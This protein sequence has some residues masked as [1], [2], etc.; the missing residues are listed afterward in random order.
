MRFS[1]KG[2]YALR[3]MLDLAAQPSQNYIPL[4]DI[5]QRQQ[6]S[7]KYLEQI[8][9]LLGK[10]HMVESIRGAAGGYR[11][12]RPASQY[13]CGDILRTTEGNLAPIPCL[14]KAV[15]DCTRQKDC[16]TLPFWVGLQ[17]VMDRYWDSVTLEDL[18]SQQQQ[19]Q[20]E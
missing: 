15:N 4:R 10:A 3:M 17:K 9:M 20:A 16:A 12:T 5:S 7:M 8:V 19:P 18:V 13:T 6:I 14:Q 1:T 11:L 2:R